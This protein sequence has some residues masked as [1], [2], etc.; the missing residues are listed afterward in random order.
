MRPHVSQFYHC[1]KHFSS[2][3][4]YRVPNND[5]SA[6]DYAPWVMVYMATC[7]VCKHPVMGW[8]P[9]DDSNQPYGLMRAIRG[10]HQEQWMEHI[11][12]SGQHYF[13]GA[14]THVQA[15]RREIP[16]DLRLVP[17]Q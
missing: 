4:V 2:K 16:F 11:R 1:K 13:R 7:P 14:H 8:R 10:K 5:I 3:Q 15:S 17:V 12:L 6:A 9:L